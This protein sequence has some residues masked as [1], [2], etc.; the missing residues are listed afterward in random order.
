MILQNE[1]HKDWVGMMEK[2]VHKIITEY[3]SY[4]IS[5]DNHT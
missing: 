4:A 5:E 3:S 2:I 1:L